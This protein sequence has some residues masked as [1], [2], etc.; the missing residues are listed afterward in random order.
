MDIM[1]SVNISLDMPDAA[2]LHNFR[3]LNSKTYRNVLLGRDFLAK[4]DR[5]EFDFAKNRVRIGKHWFPCRDVRGKETVRLKQRVSLAARSETIA[6]VKCNKSLSLVT[7]DFEPISLRSIPGVY[8][9]KCR[10]IPDVEGVF[11]ITLLN[12]NDSPIDLYARKCVGNLVSSR[13]ASLQQEPSTSKDQINPAKNLNHGEHLTTDQQFR[14]KTLITEYSDIFASNPKKPALVKNAEHR[15]I[16]G[17]A[18]PVKRKPHRIPEAWHK[19]VNTQIQEMLD[20]R[21]IRP[22]ASP[23]NAPIILVKKKDNSMRFVCDF[24]GLNDATKKDSYPLPHVRDVIDKMNGAR[25]W[26]TLDAA[27]AYWSIPLAEQ[28][29][30]KTAFSVPRGK[31]EFNVTPYGLCNAGATYQR[32]IDITLSGLPS[33]R[34]LAYMDDIVVYSKSFDEH[35]E[36]LNKVFGCLRSSSITLKLSKCVFASEH[37]DF[38]GFNLSAAGIRPQSRLTEAIDN[39]QRP[40]SKKSL[41]GFLGLA[42]FYRSFIPNFA[43]VSQPLNALTSNETPFVWNN[44]CEKA[45]N[46]LKIALTSEPVLEFPDFTRQFIVEVDASNY[47]IGGVLSQQGSDHEEHPVAY[48]ST[49]LQKS[50]Q[51][52]SATTKES[53]ALVMAV[54]HWHVY[55]A[56]R[57]FVLKTDHNPLVFLRSQKDPRGK[58]G[59]WIN[60]LEEFD[61]KIQY[62]PGKDNVKADTLSRSSAAN[63]DQPEPEFDHKIYASY[64]QSDNFKQQLATE[65]LQDPLIQNAMR[66]IA[67]NQ[68]INNGRLKRVQQQLRIENDILLK[69]GRPVVPSSLRKYIVTEYHNTAHFGTEKIYSLLKQRFYWPNMFSY[70]RT[71]V[72]NCQVCQKSKCD[73]SPPRAPM[74][75]MFIPSAPMQLVSLDIA[76]MPK[77]TH[78]YQYILLIGDVF[79]KYIQAIPLKDQSADSIRDAFLRHWLFI[80]GTPQYL[81][82]DQGSN[83]DGALMREICDLLGIEKR[84]S[85]AYHSQGNGFAERNIRTVKDMLR[86]V[87]L[88]RHLPQSKW[89]AVVTELVFALNA[90]HSKAIKCIPYEVVF[91]RSAVLPQDIIFDVVD[92]ENYEQLIPTDYERELRSTLHVVFNEV[93]KALELSKRQMQKHYNKH[94]RFH[95]YSSGEFAWLKVK[96]YK[97]GENRKLAPRR[98]GPWKIVQKLPNGV[99]FEIENSRGDR[100]VVHHDRLC[101][102]VG[103]ACMEKFDK[104]LSRRV[105][106]TSLSS[107][108]DSSSDGL[109]SSSSDS[110]QEIV[111]EE[112]NGEEIVDNAPIRAYPRRRRTNRHFPG[113]IP[114]DSLRT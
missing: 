46:A 85:S 105:S 102:V 71:F 37:V 60:E 54:R 36:S 98:D 96:H 79:S 3:V 10:I 86:A 9:T 15:I 17:D 19:E 16:T 24:R 90:S 44:E 26:S 107:Y 29:R 8:A 93:V 58:I 63:P 34:V 30:E 80:H 111:G 39:Y 52:W 2:I 45:F 72:A 35:I 110:E 5:I 40:N 113:A 33:E 41:K 108:S 95:D 14:L 55:L 47:A 109:Y 67:N 6:S 22:S 76:Y 69:S 48:F 66:N 51:N 61:Y 114:W 42:G 103:N 38:L 23:W 59:R 78:G 56:G 20:N 43:H 49:A 11:Q 81:L 77:D 53:F 68:P 18:L 27:S 91:G 70:I 99:N 112:L 65:Q 21:I 31:F 82:T 94:L 1:G 74:V 100:K 25:Y 7:A 28:D 97:T 4:F 101:P 13:I 89:R 64:I 75:P 87:L 12:V 62:I 83:V 73:T 84:R 32:M 88:H 104:T 106:Q 50:Q 92:S 57:P